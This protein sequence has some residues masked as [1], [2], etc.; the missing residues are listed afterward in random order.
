VFNN[1][2]EWCV[3]HNKRCEMAENW[4]DTADMGWDQM[5]NAQNARG[6]EG[7]GPDS[8]KHQ[9]FWTPVGVTKRIVFLDEFPFCF[10]GHSLWAITGNSWEVEICLKKHRLDKRGCPLCASEMWPSYIGNFSVIDMGTLED[11]QLKGWV[12]DKGVNYQFGRKFL[13]AKSGG[14]DKPGMLPK[15][16]RLADK[17]GGKLIGTVW[18]VYRSGQKVEAVGDE[19]EFVEQVKPTAEAIKRYLLDLGAEEKYLKVQPINYAEL[20]KPNTFERL[21][22]L[23]RG[24]SPKKDTE[25]DPPGQD[26]TFG[27]DSPPD[28]SIPF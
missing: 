14:K 25:P 22:R 11:G 7:G 4:T 19:W 20:F 5:E 3:A 26:T 12:S 15:L 1:S 8:L 21:E 13:G 9:R 28:D 6:G 18:D 24:A 16:K 2:V 23:C 27:N 10:W 17:R